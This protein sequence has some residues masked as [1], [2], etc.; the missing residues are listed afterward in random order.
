[1]GSPTFTV[2]R[3]ANDIFRISTQAARSKVQKWTNTGLVGQIGDLPN[4][5]NRPMYLY[6]AADPRLAIAMLPGEP[7]DEIC[8]NTPTSVPPASPFKTRRN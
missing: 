7:V 2:N 4:R 1:M 8:A 6:G 3:L 5:G